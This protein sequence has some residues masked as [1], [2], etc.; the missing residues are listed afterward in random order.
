MLINMVFMTGS[1]P[2]CFCKSIL[3]FGV[4][5]GAESW[6][7]HGSET[8]EKRHPVPA[9]TDPP[10]LELACLPRTS[11]GAVDGPLG[12]VLVNLNHPPEEE[13]VFL[14]PQLA[15]AVL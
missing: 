8:S 10:S 7:L 12:R 5:G 6:G 9:P 2:G 14:A 4:P 1:H 15:R 3:G 11:S 13:N